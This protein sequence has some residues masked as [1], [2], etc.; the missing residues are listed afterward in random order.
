MWKL[1]TMIGKRLDSNYN[2][3]TVVSSHLV[4]S[5][6][7]LSLTA[8]SDTAKIV[9]LQNKVMTLYYNLGAEEVTEEPEVMLHMIHA[10]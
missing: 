8:R 7:E 6:I 2:T 9:E 1:S 3:P 5:F 4:N 10:R